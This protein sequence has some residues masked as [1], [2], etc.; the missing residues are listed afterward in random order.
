MGERKGETDAG[1]GRVLRHREAAHV[2]GRKLMPVH[3]TQRRKQKNSMGEK[4]N[5]V[6]LIVCIRHGGTRDKE[7]IKRIAC[8]L[9]PFQL[10]NLGRI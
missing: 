6:D 7:S 8:I 10:K 2:K 1:A 4:G 3:Q 9:W 5:G